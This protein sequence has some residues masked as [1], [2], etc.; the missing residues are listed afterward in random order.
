[1]KEDFI[2][3]YKFNLKC[4][5][6]KKKNS[7]QNITG[8][9]HPT[10]K[11][12]EIPIGNKQLPKKAAYKNSPYSNFKLNNHYLDNIFTR[13]TDISIT[14]I[15]KDVLTKVINMVENKRQIQT[16]KHIKILE[17]LS[18]ERRKHSIR[19]FQ[20]F[21]R[22]NYTQNSV[23]NTSNYVKNNEKKIKNDIQKTTLNYLKLHY[24]NIERLSTND[25]KNNTIDFSK[26]FN[27][28]NYLNNT[29]KICN[30]NNSNYTLNNSKTKNVI[31]Q[32]NATT[33]NKMK[34]INGN[35]KKLQNL[36]KSQKIKKYFSKD[37]DKFK[38]TTYFIKSGDQ[39]YNDVLHNNSLENFNNSSYYEPHN[40]STFNINHVITSSNSNNC[41]KNYPK[42]E[43]FIENNADSI[44]SP[45]KNFIIRKKSVN[46]LHNCQSKTN[47]L[48]YNTLITEKNISLNELKKHRFTK[49]DKSAI[50]KI[51]SIS[52][53]F[54]PR[55]IIF[56]SENI[57]K[58]YIANNNI[59]DNLVNNN[60]NENSLNNRTENSQNILPNKNLNN[61]KENNICDNVKNKIININNNSPNVNVLSMNNSSINICL[62][63]KGNYDLFPRIISL[64]YPD[65]NYIDSSNNISS[66]QQFNKKNNYPMFVRKKK[67]ISSIKQRQNSISSKNNYKNPFFN[68]KCI[69]S[70]VIQFNND[71]NMHKINSYINCKN[72]NDKLSFE[73]FKNFHGN[74]FENSEYYVKDVINTPKINSNSNTN[75]TNTIH[76]IN[77][78]DNSPSGYFYSKFENITKKIYQKPSQIKSKSKLKSKRIESEE[79]QNTYSCFENNSKNIK[80]QNK[81]NNVIY[82]PTSC[83]NNSNNFGT[84][85]TVSTIEKEGSTLNKIDNIKMD[86]SFNTN[87]NKKKK[88]SIMP[89]NKRCYMEKIVYYTKQIPVIKTCYFD[90]KNINLVKHHE[91]IQKLKNN[92]EKK[93]KIIF[94]V[95]K[96]KKLNNS[97]D[98]R[99][100]QNS[101][102]K[103]EYERHSKYMHRYSCD[104]ARNEKKIIDKVKRNFIIL[105]A[106]KK[107]LNRRKIKDLND[108]GK[109]INT[110]LSILNNILVVKKNNNII[111]N[112]ILGANKLNDIFSKKNNNNNNNNKS[113][114]ILL[115][116]KLTPNNYESTINELSNLIFYTKDKNNIHCFVEIILNK[117]T[118]EKLYSNLYAKICKDLCEQNIL[119]EDKNLCC[120]IQEECSM[121]FNQNYENENISEMKFQFLGL[122]D[123]MYELLTVGII[124]INKILD[125]LEELYVKF[126]KQENNIDLKFL[127]LESVI[128]LLIYL[129]Q[130]N[131]SEKNNEKLKNILNEFI[132]NR[133]K[134]FV[135]EIDNNFVFN[136][137]ENINCINMPN[138]LK[139]KIINLFYKHY[140]GY[141]ESLYEKY[142]TNK[143]NL[144]LNSEREETISDDEIIKNKNSSKKKCVKNEHKIS[145]SPN[146]KKSLGDKNK[147]NN[148]YKYNTVD[149]TNINKKHHSKKSISKSLSNNNF[150]G[151]SNNTINENLKK[152]VLS[153]ELIFKKIDIDLNNYFIFLRNEKILKETQIN[154]YI[155][156]LFDWSITDD[157][158]KNNEVQLNDIIRGYIE[159]SKTSINETNKIFMANEYIKTIIEYYINDLSQ[160]Q[161][162]LL[163]LNMIKIYLDINNIIK[164][165]EFMYEI[166]GRL[167]FIL[168]TNKIYFMKDLN[169]FLRQSEEVLINIAKVVKFTIISSGNLAKQY[170]NDFKYTKLFTS[171]QE[172]FTHYITE[173]LNNEYGFDI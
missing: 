117:A 113:E 87:S 45:P 18:N 54:F 96:N 162:Y 58:N 110:G 114:I 163:H 118:S 26:N 83:Y 82:S 165:N 17:F 125:F 167:L 14:K 50:P 85:G 69:E 143:K 73:N 65:N 97:L 79:R 27:D 11:L 33:L 12:K 36:N 66:S 148:T 4:G 35:R 21:K 16:S 128:N 37:L 10:K 52:P 60:P 107:F 153:E 62:D 161:K 68:E 90:K 147:N 3:N 5:N 81:L 29:P 88:L 67:I 155:N 70:E 140:N 120:L 145:K 74:S 23:L 51:T 47:T 75:I 93:N 122:I 164:N 31:K 130:I 102:D 2:K 106:Q 127:Y 152:S 38:N 124:D 44:S 19:N 78:N 154:D 98:I 131:N 171:Y 121:R 41:S 169:V 101:I 42:K 25:N 115:L 80:N 8:N 53:K 112:V 172:I 138:Y 39:T 64:N 173:V 92:L 7:L 22:V 105:K 56:N 43:I 132:N 119:N 139:Y 156:N 135:I 24:K 20:K 170:H 76:N 137:S 9:N 133:F 149:Y 103:F 136:N 77:S 95:Y 40:K 32:T 91:N 134:M 100:N 86:F 46:R 84:F 61:S 141:K 59:N 55:K 150:I 89:K 109:K 159:I 30:M 157:L 57:P 108:K 166:M 94:C 15:I 49:I 48:N 13:K 6:L 168:L 104:Y 72:N 160:N 129:G 146:L 99:I 142:L 71:K 63:K 34:I 144:K 28:L 111:E 116:N 123:F 158:I 151:N 126:L 1:M